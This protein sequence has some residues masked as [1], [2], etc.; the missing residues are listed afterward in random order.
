MAK[1][2]ISFDSDWKVRGRRASHRSTTSSR[3]PGRVNR[4]TVYALEANGD[5]WSVGPLEIDSKWVRAG[6]LVQWKA[7]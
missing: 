3:T 2:T 4:G 6:N 7:R 1:P 5:S